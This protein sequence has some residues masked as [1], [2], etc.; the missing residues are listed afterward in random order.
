[1]RSLGAPLG[2]YFH[3]NRPLQLN[4]SLSLVAAQGWRPFDLQERASRASG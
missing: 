4:N 1:M 2:V 3:S